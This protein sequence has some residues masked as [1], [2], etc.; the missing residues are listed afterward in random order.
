M[1][2]TIKSYPSLATNIKITLKYQG[3]L[4]SR[5]NLGTLFT[6]YLAYLLYHPGY[7]EIGAYRFYT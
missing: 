6:F 2:Y 1:R 7:L 5:Y 3:F 4:F